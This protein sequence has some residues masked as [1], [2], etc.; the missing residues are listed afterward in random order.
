M[1]LVTIC[2]A[3]L[4][5]VLVG[6][7]SGQTEGQKQVDKLTSAINNVMKDVEAAK[8]AIQRTLDAHSQIVHNTTGDLLT[9]FK[10]F[11]KGL[12]E[13]E[14][15]DEKIAAS[16]KE[17][18]VVG[19]TFFSQWKAANDGYTSETMKKRAQERYETTLGRFKKLE[20]A[21]KEGNAAY[22][23]LIQTLKDHRL[24][25]S[26]DLNKESAA[27]LSEDDAKIKELSDTLIA[28]LNEVLEFGKQYNEAV[29]MKT[30]PPP[31][32][33]EPAKEGASEKPAES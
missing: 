14:S 11:A 18:E 4:A 8:G 5:I 29:A 24:F 22:D 9:P 12:D 2:V 27:G 20:Q 3:L 6:C 25:L 31:P 19:S 10:A 13:I 17:F 23:P 15:Y 26:N 7:E 21:A 32:T 1:R 28:A 16:V 30:T 33:E